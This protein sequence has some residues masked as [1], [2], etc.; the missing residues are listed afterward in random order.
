[1]RKFFGLCLIGSIVLFIVSC[2]SYGNKQISVALSLVDRKPD[3]A[4]S[5]LNGV[6]QFSLSDRNMAMF[7][8]AYTIAQDKSG[9]DVDK[10][11][12]LRY[13]YNW[14]K[15]KPSDSLYAKCMYYM[16]KYYML[17][18]S[19]EKAINCFEQAVRKSKEDK[20]TVYLCFSLE[21]LSKVVRIYSPQKA[22]PYA[23]NVVRMYDKASKATIPNRIYS[24][25]NLCQCLYMCNSINSALSLCHSTLRMAILYGDTFL[26]SVVYQEMASYYS[27]L[28]KSV[29]ALKCIKKSLNYKIQENEPSQ[30]ISLAWAYIDTDSLEQAEKVL[31]NLKV[32]SEMDRYTIYSLFA[33]IA[34]KRKN[35]RVFMLNNDSARYA[36]E[37]MYKKSLQGKVQYYE[38]AIKNIRKQAILEQKTYLQEGFII[39]LVIVLVFASLM[40]YYKFSYNK[41]HKKLEIEML[42]KLHKEEISHK[43]LQLTIMRNYLMKKVDISGKLQ[44]FQKNEGLH[45]L[46]DEKDWKELEEFLENADGMFVTRLKK[47]FPK[48][49]KIDVRLMMLLRIKVPQKTLSDIFCISEKAIKQK[50]YLY[51]SKV[52]IEG[53]NLSLRE[54]VETF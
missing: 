49:R 31:R 12:L 33:D 23:R 38:I 22:L 14:Y 52:G 29:E 30:K 24:R 2:S 1:M 41:K 48:L 15:D 25:L 16:G 43:N 53:K 4:I 32:K 27:S 6:D 47:E 18:D 40:V 8:L 5:V 54:W 45:I 19:S 51:K 36:L 44:S 35:I 37:N 46:L 34:M 9:L 7:S 10:D 17:N 26:I 42:E 28:G 13:A 39:L 21:K 3:S 11:S 20:D 50:L